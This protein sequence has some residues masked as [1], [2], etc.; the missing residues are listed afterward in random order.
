MSDERPPPPDLPYRIVFTPG[1]FEGTE[2]FLYDSHR[3]QAVSLQSVFRDVLRRVGHT[4]YELEIVQPP[5]HEHEFVGDEDTC[6]VER[7]CL[8]TWGEFRRKT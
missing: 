1:P 2:R 4:G 7:D 3:A 5:N 6:I 8:L